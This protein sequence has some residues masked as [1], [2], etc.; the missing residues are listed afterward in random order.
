MPG[1]VLLVNLCRIQD[2]YYTFFFS[3]KVKKKSHLVTKSNVME[4]VCH[5]ATECITK[6]ELL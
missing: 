1:A 4:K 5:S 3:C 2:I 6:M